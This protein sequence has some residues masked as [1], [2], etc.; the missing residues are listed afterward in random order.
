MKR[1]RDLLSILPIYCH[2]ILEY[3]KYNHLSLI[4]DVI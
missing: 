4:V 2:I 1:D 3:L